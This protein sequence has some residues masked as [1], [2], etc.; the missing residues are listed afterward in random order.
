MTPFE[1]ART[2]FVSYAAPMLGAAPAKV[3]VSPARD[4]VI[5]NAGA[6]SI[7]DWLGFEAEASGRS[8]R[9]WARGKQAVGSQD[10]GQP[11]DLGA[12]VRASRVGESGGMSASDLAARIV[13]MLGMGWELVATPDDYP[14]SPVPPFVTA[15][16]ATPLGVATDVE[17]Y[18]FR[19]DM[20]GGFRRP[21]RCAIHCD[22]A[23][24]RFHL[25]RVGQ[26]P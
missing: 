7:G 24:C 11:G 21:H 4:G 18:L 3:S 14:A 12:L 5:S 25:E 2:A 10:G 20:P 26:A 15:P 23:G 9:G 8:V 6:M 1:A 16:T 13:W 19:I 17:F 22:A